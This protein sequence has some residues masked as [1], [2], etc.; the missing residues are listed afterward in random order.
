MLARA[1]ACLVLDRMCEVGTAMDL[2]GVPM[3]DLAM[4][5]DLMVDGMAV[6]T[7]PGAPG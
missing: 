5:A 1:F 7:W 3:Q 4:P 2:E 6:W